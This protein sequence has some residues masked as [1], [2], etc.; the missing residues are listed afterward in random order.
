MKNFGQEDCLKLLEDCFR[1]PQKFSEF[2]KQFDK[3]W[4]KKM[5]NAKAKIE[6]GQLLPLTAF[7]L[8]KLKKERHAWAVAGLCSTKGHWPLESELKKTFTA[9]NKNCK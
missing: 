5:K 2:M 7:D 1:G 3:T 6:A 9:L 8:T 4:E